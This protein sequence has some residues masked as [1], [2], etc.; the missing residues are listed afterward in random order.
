VGSELIRLELESPILKSATV[1]RCNDGMDTYSEHKTILF[2]GRSSYNEEY[3][4]NT[5]IMQL[6]KRGAVYDIEHY[7]ICSWICDAD[8]M[9]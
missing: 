4:E 9:R 8:K 1:S 2:L 7:I 6:V 5:R 3:V